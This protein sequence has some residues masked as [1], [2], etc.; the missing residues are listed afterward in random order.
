[1]VEHN[2]SQIVTAGPLAFSHIGPG[3]VSH[4]VF[5][6]FELKHNYTVWVVVETS[7][8][9]SESPRYNFSEF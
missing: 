4:D 2:G 5:G 7:S 3:L 8:G 9:S 1:M 6:D